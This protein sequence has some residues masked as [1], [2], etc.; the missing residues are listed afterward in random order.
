MLLVKIDH[1]A[2]TEWGAQTHLLAQLLDSA[3]INNTI[4]EMIHKSLHVLI[5]E[6]LVIVHWVPSQRTLSFGS[7]F[8]HKLQHG[9][10]SFSKGSGG[11]SDSLRQSRLKWQ[12]WW[13]PD[14]DPS[15]M[16]T[17]G[18]LKQ[19]VSIAHKSHIHIE[20]RTKEGAWQSGLTEWNIPMNVSHTGGKCR[21]TAYL[22]SLRGVCLV[23]KCTPVNCS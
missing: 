16:Y 13:K 21:S 8:L 23:F 22:A 5:K 11:L 2:H 14:Q 19:P 12:S 4:V 3:D 1:V 20:I 6:P 17:S 15:T 7:V 10:L 18:R 9:F